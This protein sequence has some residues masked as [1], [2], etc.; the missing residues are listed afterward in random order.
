M[1]RLTRKIRSVI[2]KGP[3]S[4]GRGMSWMW[5]TE[6][7]DENQRCTN[8]ENERV[9]QKL[10]ENFETYEITYKL[11]TL[12]WTIYVCFVYGGKKQDEYLGSCKIARWLPYID[13][14][15]VVVDYSSQ[16]KESILKYFDTNPCVISYKKL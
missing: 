1:S 2:G 16:S 10:I 5:V 6:N 7:S 3:S 12:N 14:K 9:I 4:S 15:C 13:K 8:D 11:P